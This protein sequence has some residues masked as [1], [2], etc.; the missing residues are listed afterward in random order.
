[1][2]LQALGTGYLYSCCTTPNLSSLLAF[3]IMTMYWLILFSSILVAC[4][5]QPPENVPSPVFFISLTSVCRFNN[6]EMNPDTSFAAKG[7]LCAYAQDAN[8]M[9]SCPAGDP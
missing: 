7:S 4:Q 8:T 1:M 6:V 3:T 9:Y 5:Q 2:C